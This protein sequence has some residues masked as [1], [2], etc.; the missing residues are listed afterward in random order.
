[1]LPPPM[2]SSTLPSK[3]DTNKESQQPSI[4]MFQPPSLA[5]LLT[6]KGSLKKTN[7]VI[8]EIMQNDAP[9]PLPP[10]LPVIKKPK[11]KKK[12]C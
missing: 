1:M 9:V 2:V 8:K 10:P 5:E 7:P 11:A 3:K 6:A 4:I 12:G